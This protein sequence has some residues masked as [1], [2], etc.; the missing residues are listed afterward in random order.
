MILSSI[1]IFIFRF[2]NINSVRFVLFATIPP[3]FAAQ[4]TNKFGLF[5]KINSL[6]SF[7]EKRSASTFL[8]QQPH[9]FQENY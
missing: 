5:F 6:V 1:F 3:T 9:S 7:I 8:L 4:F 2:S